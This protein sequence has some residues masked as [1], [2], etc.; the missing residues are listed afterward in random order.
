MLKILDDDFSA[1]Q[2]FIT[3]YDKPWYEFVKSTYLNTNNSWKS[4]EF[5]TR[6]GF[7]LP[8]IREMQLKSIKQQILPNAV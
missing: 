1:Y 4:Y 3:T 2:V 5:Y 7:K 8:V 6:K